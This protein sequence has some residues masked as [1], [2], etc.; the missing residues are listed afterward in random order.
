MNHDFGTPE[1]VAV[2]FELAGEVNATRSSKLAGLLKSL[3]G[4]LGILQQSPEE[5]L[6]SGSP[7][8]SGTIQKMIH[9]RSEAKA[10]RD[11][12][13]SDSIRKSLLAMGVTLQDTPSGTTWEV[14]K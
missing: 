8:D 5:Y 12:A 11:F 4:F 1:A 6:K 9:D 13:T 2:L 3:G 10:K 7:I 14:K